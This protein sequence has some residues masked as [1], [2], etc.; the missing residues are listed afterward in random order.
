VCF[1]NLGKRLPSESRGRVVFFLC[2]LFCLCALLLDKLGSMP[3]FCYC[4]TTC[5]QI[6]KLFVCVLVTNSF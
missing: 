1:Q 4:L 6:A 3:S 2:F 5:Q